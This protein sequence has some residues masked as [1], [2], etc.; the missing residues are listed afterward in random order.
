MRKTFSHPISEDTKIL[1]VFSEN[2]SDENDIVHDIYS[3]TDD[4]IRNIEKA[5]F[6]SKTL[7]YIRNCNLDCLW[8]EDVQIVSIKNCQ[9]NCIFS[10]AQYSL[11]KV[12]ASVVRRL[13]YNKHEVTVDNVSSNYMRGISL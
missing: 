10:K 13:G 4:V 8:L 1:R 5:Y 11:F 2:T 7:I 6:K 3:D 9:I 12:K